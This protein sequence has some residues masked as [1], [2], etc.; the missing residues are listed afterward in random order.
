MLSSMSPDLQR[1]LEKFNAY[2]MLKELRIIFE[3]QAKQELFET[4]KAFHACNQ[5]DGQS[6]SSYL[7]KMR[8]Y[9]DTLECLGYAIPNELGTIAELRAML[10]LHET[11]IPKKAETPMVFA[12][13]E[14]RIHKDKKKPRG[15]KRK[16]E[17]K[18]KLAYAPKP[19]IPPSPK[20]D[21]MGNDSI[22]HHCKEVGHWR[23]N[24][25][26]Y[27]AEL[28]KNKNARGASTSS[29]FTIELYAFPNKSWVYDTSCRNHMFNTSQGLRGSM[30]LKHGA[31][32][33]YVVNGMRA[34]VEAI[35]IFD[36]V[37]PSGIWYDTYEIDDIAS[38]S[39]GMLEAS[40]SDVGLELIQED[41]IQPFENTSK[42]RGWKSAKQSTTAMS[43]TEAEYIDAAELSMEAVWIRKFID[44]L[45]DVKPLN[46]RPMEM[47]CDNA[48]AITITNDPIIMRGTRH[49][50]RKYHYIREVIQAGEI[51]LKKVHID[52]NL[53]DL[54]TK[55]M[56]Y[57]N[58]FEH[59]MGISV[60]PASSL[61]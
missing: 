11:G 30:R 24:C 32:S 37:L 40:R 34:A 42:S 45:G 49:Y 16:D 17:R 38:G 55:P 47:L 23:R 60:C 51:V 39:H 26:S 43:S 48:H 14:G 29:I 59:A 22:C 3:E 50:Q 27:Q 36:L 9:L 4:V 15:A 54:F 5:E 10:K 61:M 13:M 1:T 12:I 31:L 33:L 57:N 44:E 7:L 56:P 28:R 8:S 52:D 6:I 18:N 58:H 35:R 2:D 25:S 19:K 53:D 21:N 46:K 41:D 20:R